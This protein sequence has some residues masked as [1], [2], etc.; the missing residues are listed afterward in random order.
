MVA[1]LRYT[2][3]LVITTFHSGGTIRHRSPAAVCDCPPASAAAVAVARFWK[4]SL[5][6]GRVLF[7][8]SFADSTIGPARPKWDAAQA[9]RMARALG[10][11]VGSLKDHLRCRA[12]DSPCD[13]HGGDVVVAVGAPHVTGAEATVSLEQWSANRYR[14]ARNPVSSYRVTVRMVCKN[15]VWKAVQLT[16]RLVS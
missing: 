9:K 1:S 3:V 5:P 16:E 13:I 7:D 8:P 15:G 10:A 12:N 4:D 14:G 2:L 11:S 6:A